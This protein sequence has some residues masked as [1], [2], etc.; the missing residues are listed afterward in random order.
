M[1]RQK[2]NSLISSLILGSVLLTGCG[3]KSEC[4][5]PTRHV[6]K[7]IKNLSN[8]T[9]ITKYLDSEDLDNF[10]YKW[11]DNYI[12]VN[13]VDE[14]F[15]HEVANM[16]LGRDNW[17]YLYNLMAAQE[18]YLEFFYE[19][20]TIET[21]TETDSDGNTET[22]TRTVHHEGWHTNPYDSDNTGRVR[23]YHHRF[24][25]YKII[26]KNNKFSKVSS[27]AVDD[28]REIMDEY[29]YFPENCVTEVYEEFR[30][31]RWD[32]P[33]LSPDDFNTFNHPDLNNKS[34]T[35]NHGFGRVLK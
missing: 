35:L 28:I 11:T 23:L 34:M 29:P 12:L 8:G 18:D 30:F 33:D 6:H 16:F 20:D 14:K 2:K 3:E 22:K 19:Y 31:S 21:Y 9:A 27:Y 25:G 13:K 1:D 4:E 5:L 15:Y 17:D 10:G 7:Y 24:Y 26:Y 32:L